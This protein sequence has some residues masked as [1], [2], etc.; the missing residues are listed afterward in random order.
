MKFVLKTYTLRHLRV[1]YFVQTSTVYYE[2]GFMSS[3]CYFPIEIMNI[4][5]C[6]QVISVK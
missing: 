1:V 6:I 2:I 3:G 4:L 5:M